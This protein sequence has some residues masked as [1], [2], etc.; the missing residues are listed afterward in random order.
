MPC[1]PHHLTQPSAALPGTT[2]ALISYDVGR[3]AVV[4]REAARGIVADNLLTP[5]TD[6]HTMRRPPV[7]AQR[8]MTDR[9]SFCGSTTG[10]FNQVGGLFTL[11]MCADCQA[12]WGLGT[13]TC[14]YPVMTHAEMRAGLDL[15]PTWVL[16]Q[17]A[18][19]IRQVIAVMRKRLAASERVADAPGAGTG[20][21]GAASRSR[22]RTDRAAEVSSKMR[23][24][25]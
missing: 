3:G 21:A 13:G 12:A 5:G 18:S 14:S 1:H 20:V 9:C 24:G 10:R 2:S 22:R 4:G 15:L 17:K 7:R 16:E 23:P 25:S 6:S 19:A 8:T 11:L